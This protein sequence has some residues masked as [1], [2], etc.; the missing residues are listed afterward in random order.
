MAR[1]LVV[2]DSAVILQVIRD[3][4]VEAGHEVITA[5]NGKQ[6]LEVARTFRP[7]VILLDIE[8]PEA[9]GIEVCRILKHDPALSSI[10]VIMSSAHDRDEDVVEGLSAGAHDYVIKPYHWPAVLARI[11]AALRTKAANDLL[12]KTR[13]DAERA[14]ENERM[15]VRQLLR[16]AFDR[17]R[18]EEQL[19]ESQERFKNISD[20]A[21]DAIIM[22]DHEGLISYWNPAA[23]RIFGWSTE[24]ALGKGLHHFLAPERYHRAHEAAFPAFQQTGQGPA[25]GTVSTLS[26]LRKDGTEFPIELSLG[27]VRLGRKWSAIGVVRDIA[28]RQAE[29]AAVRESEERLQTIMQ[30]IQ[31]GI[32]VID[33]ETHQI[34]DANPA[35]TEMLH[36]SR[37]QV[38][39]RACH[40]LITT[41]GGG[42][43]PITDMGGTLDRTERELL[44]GDG[45]SLPILKT[46]VL[47]TLRGRGCLIESLVDISDRKRAEEKLKENNA[48]MVNA[49]EGEKRASMQLE[50]TMERLEEAIEQAQAATQAKSEFLANMSHEIRTP[51]TA[52][53]GFA[54]SLLDPSLAEA[55]RREAVQTIRRNGEYLL[56]IINDI[57]D[58][59][60]IEAGKLEVERV[61]FPL[62]EL[63]EEVRLLMQVRADGKGL[64]LEIEYAGAVPETI[65]SDPTRLKQ[66]LINLI[67]NAIKF[68]EQGKVRVVVRFVREEATCTNSGRPGPFVQFDVIDTGI[69]MTHEQMSRLFKSFTQGDASTTRRYG[70]TGLGLMIS[71]RLATMLGGELT[72]RSARGSGSRFSVTVGVDPLDSASLIDASAQATRTVPAPSPQPTVE[73]CRLDCRILLAED[74]PDNQRLISFVLKKMGAEVTVAENGKIAYEE[75]LTARDAGSPYDVI[76]MDMQ[77]PVLDG[78]T[79]TRQLRE[80][81]YSGPIIALTAHAMANDRAHCLDAGCDDYAAKPIDRLKLQ[82]AIAAQLS[83]ERQ[84]PRT[85]HRSSNALIDGLEGDPE[86]E[87]LI[88]TFVNNLRERVDA[89][90]RH[91]ADGDLAALASLA[92]QIKGTS[93]NY[94]FPELGDQAKRVE[95]AAKTGMDLESLA[96]VVGHLIDMCGRVCATSGRAS[97]SETPSA[98]RASHQ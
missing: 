83:D 74:G 77:M 36:S 8:M 28:K 37:E 87:E 5:G 24:E 42:K 47:A 93:G 98:T 14:F 19:R 73:R 58:I 82:E 90:K 79:A 54:E 72:V 63:I 97:T 68:T 48:M 18:V 78:Y 1:I 64:P 65:R 34:V 3:Q 45:T 75:A 32:L 81:G 35:A 57:L 38:I 9:D 4:L 46:A 21:L 61:A 96:N 29:E 94:G 91:L 11:Q 40:D 69:G 92:H 86:I 62:V 43:C 88:S 60:K 84:A 31:T 10:P 71:K 39:G 6:T 17:K 15:L 41:A 80:A 49:L 30:S 25:V 51:M 59:S 55:D 27:S 76:L 33:A 53:L 12:E 7:D 44:R 89:L 70:G 20:H 56:E 50:A 95:Q 16:E 52:I 26:A 22:M 67:G 66:I 85:R 23:E 2:D 13:R